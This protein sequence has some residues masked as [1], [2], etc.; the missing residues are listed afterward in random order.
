[1]ARTP[2]PEPTSVTIRPFRNRDAEPSSA[3]LVFRPVFCP[4]KLVFLAQILEKVSSYRL[5][6]AKTVKNDNIF[7]ETKSR[8][9]K[10]EWSFDQNCPKMPKLLKSWSKIVQ[11]SA[12]KRVHSH[13]YEMPGTVP[14]WPS[15]S[16]FPS[17]E[18]KNGWATRLASYA[19]FTK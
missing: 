10:I 13:T 12:R 15:P 16:R 17:R 4:K 9:P 11:K 1:M 5:R 6:P 14:I 8:R 3:R 18:T 7:Y 19:N 2:A